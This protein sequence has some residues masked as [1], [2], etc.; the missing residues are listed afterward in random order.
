MEIYAAMVS[1]LDAYIGRFVAYLESIDEL[2]N[3]LIIFM[4]DNGPE[5]ARRDLG[6]PLSAWVETC[7]DN[8]Y[9]NLGSGTS[10]VMYGPN[11]AR[12]SSAPFRRSKATAFEGGTHV[13]AFFNMP[14]R[15]PAGRRFD[16]FGAVVDIL[17][18]VLDVAGV[19]L[20]GEQFRGHAILP[21]A[22]K[23]LLPALTNSGPPLSA[24]V[25]YFG[26]EL[27]GHRAIREGDWKIVWDPSERDA[28]AWHLFD[29]ARDPG[30]QNDLAAREP[31][32][33]SRLTSLWDDYVARN[34][35]IMA[36]PVAR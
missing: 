27:Y 22:G 35:V 12:A 34:G 1:D 5:G 36:R 16:G 17:P 31:A 28:A 24:P 20:P 15:I 11:W 7:C 4:S 29:I 3:T 10:Y 8:S 2:D 6:R 23:S 9:E 14:G 26:W 32:R 18:T 30:E 33:L 21:L 13:P 19:A 25:D